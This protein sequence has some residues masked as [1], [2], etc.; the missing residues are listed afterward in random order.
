MREV[1]RH[2]LF[3]AV[4]ALGGGLAYSQAKPVPGSP[5][6]TGAQQR[7]AQFNL[8]DYGVTFQPDTR[9]IVVMAALDAAG[10]DPTPPGK[11]PSVFRARV[12]KDQAELDQSLRDRLHAFYEHNKLPAPA[13]SADQAARYI[14]LAY[15]LGPTPS[16]DAPE[17]S[18]D[19]PGG[20]LEVLDFAPL[21]REFYRKSG[22][23]ERLVSYVRAYQ[24]EG[25]R[26]R[27]PASEMVRAV[28]S[29]L[30]T[31]PI[32]IAGERVLVKAP[33]G[34]K[35]NNAPRTYALREHERH[36]YIVPDLLAAP[37][38]INL[39]VIAD[40]YYAIVPEGTDPASSELRRAYL[41]YVIDP[42]MLRFGKE[43]VARREQIKQLLKER[44]NEGV[45]VTP[46]VFLVVSR[47]LVAAADARFEELTKLEAIS[48]DAR[49]RLAKAKDDAARAA[50]AKEAQASASAIEN[51]KIARLA[52]E[53]ENG[54]VLAFFFADQ[55]KGIE[56]SGFDIA[57]FFPD[58]IASF[59]PAR[60][61]RRLT[62][63]AAARAR[64]IAARQARL[65]KRSEEET[66][67]YSD[68]EAAK[69][70]SL[71]KG[72]TEVEGLL[73]QKD[74]NGAESRLR[75]LMKDY[76][77][78]PRIFFALAQT[79][80]VGAADATD[81]EV[82]AQRLNNALANYRLAVAAA[83]P[84]TDRALLSRAHEAMG[85]IYEFMEKRAEAA[86]EFD[87]AIKLDRVPGGAYDQALEGKKRLAPPN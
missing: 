16:L 87:E 49:A 1:K 25:D 35:K 77:R 28:L 55:L 66:P 21:L 15:A 54:A 59:D 12:K 74:Y 48:I 42:L 64:A 5:N 19:L 14:S 11:Q 39:R 52:D 13:T 6:Q 76:P 36:F 81:E 84:E 22:I 61:S 9:L 17:R 18:D 23:D 38:T 7:P 45:T 78:E 83:S 2:L 46:D 85:R 27:P 79:S 29:Y 47:S 56:S 44:E 62:D 68:A 43:I 34:K 71:V 57:N 10:F 75:E 20:V 33:T 31:Q 3:A 65:A 50:I 41:Q 51:D 72:L 70:A 32:T 53:Y 67:I 40:D 8:S 4:I 86:K 73:R 60:E 82:Q 24:A 63:N 37:G 80:S 26:L 30:H 69:A 58:M